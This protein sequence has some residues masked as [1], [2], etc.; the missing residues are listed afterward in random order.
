MTLQTSNNNELKVSDTVAHSGETQTP[1]SDA[2]ASLNKLHSFISLKNTSRPLLCPN[3]ID[4]GNGLVLRRAEPGDRD[5]LAAFNAHIHFPSGGRG[6]FDYFSPSN[7][8]GAEHPTTDHTNFTVVVD[9]AKNNK[10]VSSVWSVPQIWYYGNPDTLATESNALETGVPIVVVRPEGVGTDE[11]YRGH[12]LIKKHMDVHHEWARALGSPL[13]FIGGMPQYYCRFGY[14]CAPERIAGVGGTL[15]SL[16]PLIKK[17]DPRFQVRQATL[18]DVDF[19]M[20]TVRV[21]SSRRDGI[22]TDVDQFGWTSI[23]K[24]PYHHYVVE[25]VSDSPESSKE[26][27]RI[28]FVE[29][30]SYSGNI[31]RLELADTDVASWEDFTSA[32]LAFVPQFHKEVMAGVKKQIQAPYT[33]PRKMKNSNTLPNDWQFFLSLGARH[34]AYKSVAATCLP[35]KRDPY[36]WFTRIESVQHLLNTYTFSITKSDYNAGGA[37]LIRLRE[38]RFGSV[39][40]KGGQF[41]TFQGNTAT[42]IR[43]GHPKCVDVLDVLFPRMAND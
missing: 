27:V 41:V 42:R 29:F 12:G 30:K 16:E 14:E 24:G 39:I 22:W 17:K 23:M 15:A 26:P 9:T 37:P 20:T 8:E 38:A 21:N 3:P 11:E 10:I 18:D 35:L 4:L 19:I 34:P 2:Q 43:Y 36:Y 28:G 32:V 1:L 33:A 31:Q 40:E 5:E 6:T 7:F 13:Q 25:F